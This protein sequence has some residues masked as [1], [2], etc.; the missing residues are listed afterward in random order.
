[1]KKLENEQ[2]LEQEKKD[3][4]LESLKLEIQMAQQHTP[5]TLKKYIIDSNER[6]YRQLKM[7]ETRVNQFV[8]SDDPSSLSL[9]T[10][11]PGFSLP[12][13]Q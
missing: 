2:K 11:L 3:F 7:G 12:I 1:M 6:I 5:V 8:S 13:G 9:G 10:L 4:E